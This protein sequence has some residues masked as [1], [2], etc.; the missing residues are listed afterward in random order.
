MG[1][2][3]WPSWLQLWGAVAVCL[4]LLLI[5]WEQAGV[6]PQRLG[7]LAA[8]FKALGPELCPCS[9]PRP[10]PAPWDADLGSEQV[11]P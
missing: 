9:P 2:G 10:L 4:F 6:E 5:P 1:R 3:S 7:C 8:L 11:S